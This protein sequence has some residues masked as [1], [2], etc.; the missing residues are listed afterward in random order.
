[1]S[2]RLGRSTL[3][4]RVAD[5]ALRTPDAVAVQ[6]G[7]DTLS[8]A[9]LDARANRLA[10]HLRGLGVGA[11][12][13]VGLCLERCL[14]LPIAMLG[15]LKAGGAYLPLDP[16]YPSPRLLFMLE[17]AKAPVLVTDRDLLGTFRSYR[18]S[19]VLMSGEW[20]SDPNLS[21]D[22]PEGRAH[23][24]NLAY[25][26][27]TSGST[28]A[29]KGVLVE[30]ASA[31]NVLEN[32]EGI[33]GASRRDVLL[34]ASTLAFD[35]ACL[36][37]FLPLAVGG[38]VVIVS[39]EDS[40]FGRRISHWLA[41]SRA[42]VLQATPSTWRMLLDSGWDGGTTLKMV[43]TGDVLTTTL[44]HALLSRGGRLWN[45]YSTTEAGIYST[46]HEV[47]DD[48]SPI[49]VGRPIENVSAYI[50]GK[51]GLPV[52]EGEIGEICI[53]GAGLA[54]G[55]LNRPDLTDERF[56]ADPFAADLGA[57]MYRTG[58][59]GRWFP[60]GSI[61]FIGRVDHQFKV[62]GYR[63]EPGEIEATL[64][65]HPC[66]AEAVV[67]GWQDEFGKQR[68]VAYVVLAEGRT[69][70]PLDLRRYTM[71]QLPAYM[72]PAAVVILDQLPLT[73]NRK[74]DRLALPPP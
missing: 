6:F 54:R 47:L 37:V 16:A 32:M 3:H 14:E 44:A 71:D 55:Y 33:L 8:Y 24:R 42:T 43:C 2:A 18:N 5:Q 57:R 40:M 48:E 66:V 31:R 64:I 7:E 29:P 49:P 27:Y 1:M 21:E 9:Q 39:R 62:R 30:H 50:L 58:D 25:V 74:V 61:A 22:A 20:R 12:V 38:R 46:I 59:F 23:G 35:I 69:A 17:D 10:H 19:I 60:D 11:D 53:A 73:P 52:A 36:D 56:V 68:P 34:A 28:G 65:A 26:I 51:E 15:I 41:R 63:V 72:V 67:V 4:Q 13:P 70:R 45:A